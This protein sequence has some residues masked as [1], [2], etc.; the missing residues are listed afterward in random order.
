MII[1]DSE[2]DQTDKKSQHISLHNMRCSFSLL[3]GDAIKSKLSYFNVICSYSIGHGNWIY[4]LLASQKN[5][6]TES[7]LI[8]QHQQHQSYAVLLKVFSS[9]SLEMST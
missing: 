7:S 1:T 3:G 2:K 9:K 6:L 5:V 4:F 8:V